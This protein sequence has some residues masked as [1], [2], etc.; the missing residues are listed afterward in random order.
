MGKWGNREIEKRGTRENGGN[1]EMGQS[2]KWR[3]G[4]GRNSE[5]RE[6]K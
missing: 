4:E 1:R 6:S 3:H 2:I 5:N